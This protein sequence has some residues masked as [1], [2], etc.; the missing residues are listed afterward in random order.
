[1]TET[2]PLDPRASLHGRQDVVDAIAGLAAGAAAGHGGALTV[3]GEAGIGKTAVLDEAAQLV[4]ADLPE[5]RILRLRGVEAE[6]E[7][8]WSGLAELLDG[9]LDGID[10]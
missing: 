8:A 4:L 10:R 7:L 5:S 3:V 6:L 9:V 2:A 1:M